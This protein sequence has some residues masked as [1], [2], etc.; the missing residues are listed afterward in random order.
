MGLSIQNVFGRIEGAI[1]A[2]G[3]VGEQSAEIYKKALN[4][5]IGEA[6]IA[7][8]KM[9]Q[10]DQYKFDVLMAKFR[11]FK[12]RMGAEVS[13]WFLNL[14]EW[15]N[16]NKKQLTEIWNDTFVPMK[17]IVVSL[18]GALGSVATALNGDVLDGLTT[19][20]TLIGSVV[21]VKLGYLAVTFGIATVAAIKA[22]IAAGSFAV[23]M[24]AATGGI[25][26]IIP[27]LA[28]VATGLYTAYR[29]C[30]GFR[31][32]ID[33]VGRF[34][35]DV[36]WPILKATGEVFIAGIA[37]A[38]E[39]AWGVI[40]GI[41]QIIKGV[42]TLD[43][44]QIWEGAKTIFTTA[45]NAL[46]TFFGTIKDSFGEL[47]LLAAIGILDGFSWAINGIKNGFVGA[48]NWVLRKAFDFV[49]G[50]AALLDEVPGIDGIQDRVC[51]LYTS[52]SPRDS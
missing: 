18:A 29:K 48:F 1:A 40:K 22:T 43:W 4:I 33:A 9:R 10:I 12:I 19:V 52:P 14:E 46:M 7:A 3:L 38:F 35:R 50:L 23:A 26:L 30:E 13:D 36:I 20:A 27:A 37:A 24:T 6:E 31:N 11:D 8:E 45:W 5:Q 17:D 49:S 42:F 32:V 25:N 16:A 15:W 39:A 34:L 47:A 44:S 51:L 28:L 2:T 21:I 41:V